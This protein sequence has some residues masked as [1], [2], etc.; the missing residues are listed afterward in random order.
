MNNKLVTTS[1]AGNP[2]RKGHNFE[3]LIAKYLKQHLGHDVKSTREAS[4]TLDNC[5]IDLI[6]T[7]FLI[8][9]KAGYD[10]RRPRY[11]EVYGYIKSNLVKHFSSDHRIHEYPILLIHNIDVGRGNKRG[12]EHTTVTMTM[13]DYVNLRKGNILPILQIL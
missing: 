3:R 6:N 10:N 4:K 7:D 2:R 11:E 1:K 13:E 12:V 5:G 9:C 8:Q